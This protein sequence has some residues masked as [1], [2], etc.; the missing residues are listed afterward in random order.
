MFDTT[1]KALHTAQLND[2][3]SSPELSLDEEHEE[4]R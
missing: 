3:F 1:P 4:M 2:E